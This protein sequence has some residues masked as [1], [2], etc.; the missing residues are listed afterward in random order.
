MALIVEGSWGARN[1]LSARQ[2]KVHPGLVASIARPANECSYGPPAGS[3]QTKLS[4]NE[5][6]FGSPYPEKSYKLGI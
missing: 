5:T 6:D 2:H 1:R 4:T 3:G